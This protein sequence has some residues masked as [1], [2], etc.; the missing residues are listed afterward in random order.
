MPF[1]FSLHA[2]LRCR[3]SFEQRERQRLQIL[4]REIIKTQQQLTAAKQD[5]ARASAQMQ[6]KSQQGITS[7]ELQFEL[8]CDRA[9]LRTITALTEKVAKLENLRCRQLELFRKARQQRQILENLRERQ[10]AAYRLVQARR[11]QQQMDDRFVITRFH[12][13]ENAM[14]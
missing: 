7:V 14:P 9:R 12:Q 10:L 2:L 11:E 5:R 8:A 4:M 6:R 13:Q 1:R 3:E